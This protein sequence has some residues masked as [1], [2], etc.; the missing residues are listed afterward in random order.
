MPKPSYTDLAPIAALAT[1]PGPA[2]L[3]VIR[4]TGPGSLD[5]LARV[6]SRPAA[7]R[8][9][10][11]NTIIYGWIM[12][13]GEASPLAPALRSFATPLSGGVP[14]QRPP[15][16]LAQDLLDPC[17]GVSEKRGEALPETPEAGNARDPLCGDK[18]MRRMVL[19]AHH[20]RPWTDAI[21]RAP[22][23]GNPKPD[24]EGWRHPP[25]TPPIPSG[26][27]DDRAETTPP[28]IRARIDEVLVSVYRAPRSY[29][30]EDGAD[31][32]CHG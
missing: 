28:E 14:P 29:T 15:I 24:V 7:L 9:A 12:K 2:A 4:T 5:L 19:W 25:A 8:E 6:F 18:T 31:I 16:P 11:G 32:I 10:P 22:R 3:A 20:K 26:G 13:E 21:P 27:N 17:R 1:A 23:A 30:G